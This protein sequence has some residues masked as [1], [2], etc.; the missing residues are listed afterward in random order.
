[1]EATMAKLRTIAWSDLVD[2]HTRRALATEGLRRLPELVF[3]PADL[4]A[5]KDDDLALFEDH[6]RVRGLGRGVFWHDAEE[7]RSRRLDMR[8][9]L[10]LE[11]GPL[12]MEE[13]DGDEPGIRLS[14]G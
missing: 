6:D 11:R 7:C 8:G 2:V 12:E 1:M 5:E 14:F 4:P 13:D 3:E 9:P 10:D